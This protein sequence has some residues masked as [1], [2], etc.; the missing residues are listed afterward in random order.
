[1]LTTSVKN[2][3]SSRAGPSSPVI[4]LSSALR[5]CVCASSTIAENKEMAVRNRRNATRRLMQPFGIFRAHQRDVGGELAQ[6]CR[7]NFLKR[8][9]NIKLAREHDGSELDGLRFIARGQPIAAFGLARDRQLDRN[10]LGQPVREL[11][12]LG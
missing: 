3:S 2:T 6:A 12:Q 4:H 1:G 9:L 11:E 10:L 5:A 7:G 8:V